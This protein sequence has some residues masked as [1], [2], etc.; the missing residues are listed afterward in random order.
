M[1]RPGATQAPQPQGAELRRAERYTV[2]LRT[3]KIIE[4]GR[5]FLCV[6]RDVSATGVKL[7]I[8]HR[9]PP[10]KLVLELNDGQR[11]MIE[12]MW[13]DGEHAGCRFDEPVDVRRFLET[14]GDP[15][16]RRKV[17]L[18]LQKQARLVVRGQQFEVRLSNLSG[19]GAGIESDV[20]LMQYEPVR[21]E[22]AGMPVLYGKVCW[23]EPPRYGIV[24]DFGFRLEQ[25]AA[26]VAALQGLA[27]A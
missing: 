12:P 11:F 18:N 20:P 5:E 19:H 22:V 2:L 24:F 15:Y 3:A 16:N 25:L 21:M 13:C 8:F 9:L 17:R 26:H 4:G 6:L 10:G 1:I 23:A 14:S 27:G 7:K